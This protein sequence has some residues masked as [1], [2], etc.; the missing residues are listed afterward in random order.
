MGPGAVG[1][2]VSRA[3]GQPTGVGNYALTLVK[4]LAQVD[5]ESRYILYPEFGP[6]VHADYP[7]RTGAR[8]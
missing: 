7:E 4:S 2:D 3:I 5:R 1:I 8:W 6:F